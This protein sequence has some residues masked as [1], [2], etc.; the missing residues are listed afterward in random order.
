MPPFRISIE[1]L[2]TLLRLSSVG[3]SLKTK[4][5][6][7]SCGY[8]A[9][10][11]DLMG[12]FMVDLPHYIKVT[13]F[14]AFRWCGWDLFA[15]FRRSPLSFYGRGTGDAEPDP[16]RLQLFFHPA[17]KGVSSMKLLFS[18]YRRTFAIVPL[19]AVLLSLSTYAASQETTGGVEGYVTDA[20]GATVGK[21]TIVLTGDKL[22]GA[23]KIVTDS[24]GF[25]KFTAIDPGTYTLTVVAP[26]FKELKRESLA[27]EVGR[28][29]SIN[30]A[31]AVGAESSVVEVTTETP[32]IDVTQSRTQTDVSR[33]ELDYLPRGL[34]FQSVMAFAP[35]ARNEPLQGG[36]QVDGAATAENSY[37]IEGQET[38][39]LVTGKSSANVPTEFLEEVQI[40]TS[41]IEAE[42]GGAMGGV[43]NAIQ[44][45]GSNVV[46]GELWTYYEADPM[47][48]SPATTLRYDPTASY[49][50][51]AR[52]DYAIQNYTPIKDHFRTV[53]P[54]FLVGGPLITDRLWYV[55]SFAPTYNTR[56]RNVNFTN[57]TCLAA[58]NC[59]GA[60]IFNQS[61]QTYFAFGRL[62]YKVTDKIRL[63]A[64]GEYAYD[65]A[66]GTAFPNPDSVEGLPNSSVGSPVDSFNGS[67]GYVAPN[68]LFSAGADVTL[69]PTLVAST[70]V[71]QFYQNYGD[72]GLPNGD[73]Y[74]LLVNTPTSAT[75][76]S[77]VTALDGTLLENAYK[78]IS[79]QASG[80]ANIAG[81]EGYGYNVNTR[82]TFNQDFSW[83][84][85]NLYG[86][87]NFKFGYQL[88]HLYENVNQTFTNDLVRL[89]Y[90]QSYGAQTTV[91]AA[92]CAS[93]VAANKVA[94]KTTSTSCQ[95]N[96]GYIVLRDGV[97]VTG[98]ASSNNH[99]L[100]AQDSWQIK[101]RLTL[102][103]GLR[104]EKEYLPSYNKYPSGISFG[105]GDKIAPRLGAA[106][107]VFGN[108]KLKAF[109]SY[110]VFY[111]LMHLN[112]AIG[113]FGGNYWHDCVYALD[114]GDYSGIHPAKDATGHYCPAGGSTVQG[115]FSTGSTP[116]YLR[117]IE[118]VDYRI[119][120]N[121]PSQGA[122]VDPN[123]KPYREHQ[124]VAGLDS[125]LTSK[126]SFESRYTRVRLD[127]AIEDVGYVGPNGEEFIIANPGFYTDAGG[128]TTSCPSCKAQPKAERDY[129]ALELR[130]TRSLTKGLFTQVAYTY[131]RLRGNYSGLTSTD[132]ADGGGARA[133]PN[134]NRSFDEPQFQFAADGSVSNGL[135]STDRPN[136]FKVLTYFEHK[137]LNRNTVSI[138]LFEQASS[139]SP[140]SSYADVNGSAG[141]YPVYVVGRGKW[142]D[143]TKGPGGAWVYGST[144]TKR[145]PWFVQSD[146]SL[147][148]S[149][150]VSKE[151][152]AWRLGFEANITNAL[153][154]KAATVFQSRIN[155][156]SGSTGNYILPA[157]TTSGNPNYG[158]LENGYDW[159][160]IANVGNG[161]STSRGPLVLNNEYG[162]ASSYQAGRAIRVKVKFTF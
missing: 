150:A 36:F 19:L 54:G 16:V 24:S 102:N 70:R 94:Y 46:H 20:S 116:S 83:F 2:D 105:F 44:K 57:A 59:L 21:A 139:G 117:F 103:V 74:L 18:L 144:Y 134:N 14:H 90:G 86:S 91:G 124:V 17:T 148:E 137:L 133:N 45:K 8:L 37:L 142:I 87:H 5:S 49:S 101:K 98:Q 41:G 47:D 113:S 129:D 48:A 126:I 121:D 51:A 100:Y 115:N 4:F 25:Y 64:S 154:A 108:G 151:H 30:L 10:A 79:G 130:A 114:K 99:S 111:D 82:T 92:N 158:V 88:N 123:I 152:D 67:I 26:G 77:P 76:S 38:G 157:N 43:V 89:S 42:F 65:R 58:G 153:N 160:S 66:I 80:Y 140:L 23:K 93:I 9:I 39:S 28:V 141:S 55:G 159:K 53:T 146:V 127:H 119:P 33:E 1:R 75:S 3:D 81:N 156:A 12:F 118:N 106:Y 50:T 95:G 128:P 35:G 73:R 27:I 52:S 13:E 97:E 147:T 96:Y 31:L 143:V 136:S 15:L 6:E 138:S 149:Y 34:S 62:D 131:S 112:L 60:R 145:T 110:G 72:R 85:G 107:D 161:Q 69:T 109:G 135:L 68:V 155:A 132:I 125:Q 71:S 32:Q 84:K 162:V 122:A 40:K 22:I 11:V 78:P 29:P 120:S 104:I 7:K 56:R 63:Y 61:E